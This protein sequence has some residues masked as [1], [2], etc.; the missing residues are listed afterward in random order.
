M[1]CSP[2]HQT[3][4]HPHA[5]VT[6]IREDATVIVNYRDY[7]TVN[8]GNEGQT[9]SRYNENEVQEGRNTPNKNEKTN[10]VLEMSIRT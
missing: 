7:T 3:E 8:Q 9:E 2:Y 1:R 10:N 4:E 6:Q 5:E